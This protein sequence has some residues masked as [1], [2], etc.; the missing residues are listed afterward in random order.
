[1]NSFHF[2]DFHFGAFSLHQPQFGVNKSVSAVTNTGKE[3]QQQVT[4]V[5]SCFFSS[6]KPANNY[7]SCTQSANASF[8]TE[9]NSTKVIIFPIETGELRVIAARENKEKYEATV[10]KVLETSKFNTIFN[11]N[12]INA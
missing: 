8:Y 11:Q 5:K 10:F 6:I 4:R 7:G 2:G 9:A 12:L 3:K 1:M